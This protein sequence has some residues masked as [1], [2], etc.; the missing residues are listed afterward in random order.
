[1]RRPPAALLALALVLGGCAQPAEPEGDPTAHAW[2]L[3]TGTLDGAPIL[4]VESHP[5][6][7]SFTDDSAGG[8]AAC[9]GYGG[10]YTISGAELTFAPPAVTEMACMPE[11][12][13]ESETMYLAALVRVSNFT[14]DE[15]RMTLTGEGVEMVFAQLPP[16]PTAQMTG[17]VWVLDA[18]VQGEAVS[19]VMGDRATLEMFSDGS[20]LGSTGCRSFAGSYTVNGSG[21][22]VTDLTAEGE[23]TDDLRDQDALVLTV[24]GDGFR[25]TIEGQ[26]M[27]LDST[28]NQG[29]IYRAES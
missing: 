16:V 11:Q 7:L 17:T 6:T 3:E 27:T 20:L 26:G 1:M 9:N 13:M 29:L 18:L 25:V 2:Q 5:I 4:I 23:C 19:S 10:P 14:I 8:T 15:E 24:L 28:G 22:L 12:V 21:V